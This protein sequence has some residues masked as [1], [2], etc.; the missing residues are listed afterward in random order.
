[1]NI[2]EKI[3]A[4]C[5]EKGVT[6][7]SVERDAGVGNGVIDDWRTSNPRVDTLKKVADALGVSVADLLAE[8]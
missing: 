3:K 6:I 7:A 2:Y 5:I 4:L 1:M 8:A